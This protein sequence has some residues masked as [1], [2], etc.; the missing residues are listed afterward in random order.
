MVRLTRLRAVLVAAGVAAVL[1]GASAGSAVGADAALK[2]GCDPPPS[3]LPDNCS[4][5]HTGPVTLYWTWNTIDYQ[6]V[7]GVPGNDCSSPHRMTVDTSGSRV[8]CAVWDSSMQIVNEVATIRIDTTPPTVTGMTPSRPADHDG[9][10][11]HPVS[12]AF[13]ASDA[14]SGIAG[15][16]T[17]SY[18]GPDG[19]AAPVSGGCRDVAGN[20]SSAAFPIRYDA[21]PPSIRPGKARAGNARVT[22]DWSTSPDVVQTTVT[23][24]PGKG[25]APSTE[26]YSGA[27]HSFTDRTVTNGRRYTYTVTAADPA[28]NTAS[29]TMA[30]TPLT[31][32]PRLR[33]RGVRGADYYNVQLYKS[34][35]KVLSAWPRG[36]HL[37]LRRRWTFRGRRHVLTAGHYDWY[38]WPGFGSRSQHRYGRLIVHRSFT[39]TAPR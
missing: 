10:W 17:V 23:R 5:W 4:L 31:P 14:T 6:P 20:S 9:W 19:D 2:Y 21:T 3:R 38:A 11:N 36:T 32:P 26:L 28:A 34:G 18:A 12:F 25:R 22:I 33:W 7:P 27:G 24:S 8:L 1:T 39:V 29:L 37:Q 16:D 13:T 35:R 30:A 15:C